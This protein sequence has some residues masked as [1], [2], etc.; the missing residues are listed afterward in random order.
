[1]KTVG[2]IT[3][4]LLGVLLFS[5]SF[6]FPDWGDL[7]SPAS[8]HVSPY[9]I[10]KSLED[11]SVPNIVTAVLA[12]YRGYDTMFET[13]VIFS[14]GLACF[15]LLRLPERKVSTAK[16]YRHLTTGITI[17]IEKGGH[18]PEDTGEFERIDS[19]WVPYDVIISTTSRLVVPFIQ[20]F[21]L[22][23]IAHGHHSP[24]GGFQGGV[25]FGAAII[26]FALSNNL[27]RTLS[28]MS[29]RASGL[30]S[31]LGVLI[32]AGVGGLCM[33]LGA[34]FLNYRALAPLLGVD[35]VSA[36][37]LGVLFVEIGVGIAVTAVMVW[38]Y[39]NLSSAG[40]QDEGL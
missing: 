7:N 39:Y 32:Y 21:A 31:S 15:F 12:D 36:R 13:A 9:Y 34:G 18:L 3:V 37:S 38:I 8:L 20:L 23:V 4:F 2:A 30:L 16:L 14:A 10:E 28:R 5:A 6:E 29:E 11:T 40:K 25:I 22:Y 26:L 24:G 19:V 17:R 35:Q 1:M 27:R 33:V